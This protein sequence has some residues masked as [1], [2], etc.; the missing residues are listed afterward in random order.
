MSFRQGDKVFWIDD[1]HEL[2]RR[3]IPVVLLTD[4]YVPTWDIHVE[5]VEV[6]SLGEEILVGYKGRSHLVAT[7]DL[8]RENPGPR[9]R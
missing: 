5:V 3:V 7:K 8:R 1:S 4:P 9:S 6:G 2:G